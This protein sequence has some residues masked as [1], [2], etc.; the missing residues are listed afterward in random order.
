MINET[1]IVL[2]YNTF[3]EHFF[4][5]TQAKP[6]SCL[7]SLLVLWYLVT[8]SK[9]LKVGPLINTLSHI[10]LFQSNKSVMG[11]DE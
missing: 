2:V 6:L 9:M 5:T 7:S 8:I 3:K 4:Q 11:S 1:L 10:C